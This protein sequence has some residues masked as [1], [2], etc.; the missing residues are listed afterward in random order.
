[1]RENG[2]VERYKARLVVQGDKQI[3]GVN[4]NL[5]FSTVMPIG[6]A[7]VLYTFSRLW[8]VSASTV[9]FQSPTQKLSRTQIPN[10]Y[11]R[12]PDGMT[13]T[14]ETLD[15]LGVKE[16]DESVLLLV[17]SLYSLKQAGRLWH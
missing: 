11:L 1:M 8:G 12:I 16:P 4:Y 15:R 2:S 6:N 7:F 10:H 17:R 14:N 9:T 3:F 13:V 5:T